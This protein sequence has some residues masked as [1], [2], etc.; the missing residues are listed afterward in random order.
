MIVYAYDERGLDIPHR[1]STRESV[2]DYKIVSIAETDSLH[3]AVEKIRQK[4]RHER[5]IWLLRI[6]AHGFPGGF[7]FGNGRVNVGNVSLLHDLAAY[8]TPGGRGI[9][10]H[11]CNVASATGSLTREIAIGGDGSATCMSDRGTPGRS[12]G[13]GYA[14]MHALAETTGVAVVGSY[15]TQYADSGFRWEGR[16]TMTVELGGTTITTVGPDVRPQ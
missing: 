13:V 11:C 14:F 6:I 9:E 1:A 16:G 4:A 7:Q 3:D 12:S 2:T 10:L 8:F 15:D 5:N